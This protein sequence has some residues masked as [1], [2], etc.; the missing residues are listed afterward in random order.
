MT[1]RFILAAAV[2]AGSMPLGAQAT[3]DP[4]AVRRVAEEFLRV[5]TRGLP[6]SVS[7]DVGSIDPHNQLAPC[8][9][10][11]AYSPAG[12]NLWGRTTVGIRCRSEEGWQIF[13]SA[14]V[15]VITEVLVAARALPA[16]SIIGDADVSTRTADL[17][18]MP[19][20]ALTDR[21]QAV[22]NRLRVGIPAG[23]PLRSDLVQAPHVV[24]QGQSVTV[25]SRGAGFQVATEG[26]ALNDAAVGQIAQIRTGSGQTVSGIARRPGV[27]E[28]VF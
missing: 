15:R 22:G 7:F 5:Q 20:G 18:E 6:G 9:S 25:V 17:G 16:G 26:R 27:V 13:V 2:L 28:V 10:L 8:R 11:E 21:P 14:R 19:A 3:Q 23:V 24:Q 12:S 4:Q 1:Y